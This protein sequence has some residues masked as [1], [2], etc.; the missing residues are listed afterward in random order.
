MAR[1]KLKMSK[2]AKASRKYYRKHRGKIKR[3]R[4]RKRC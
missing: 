3:K 4:K 2:A 1:K